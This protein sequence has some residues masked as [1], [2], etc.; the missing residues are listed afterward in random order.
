VLFKC[1]S[2]FQFS[3]PTAMFTVDRPFS[4]GYFLKT[5]FNKPK[6]TQNKNW[7]RVGFPSHDRPSSSFEMYYMKC[8]LTVAV[9]GVINLPEVFVQKCSDRH[10]NPHHA[11]TK[12]GSYC[13]TTLCH[14]Q[15]TKLTEQFEPGHALSEFYMHAQSRQRLVG[16]RVNILPN[17]NKNH[18][19]WLAVYGH[20][21]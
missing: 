6:E 12:R 8:L 16:N 19:T 20:T 15:I 4:F 14:P 21:I 3:R 10:S 1:Y 11:R 13:Y 17:P 9:R 7:K 5:L 2:L 18:E